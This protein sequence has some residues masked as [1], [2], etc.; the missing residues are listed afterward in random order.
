MIARSDATLFESTSTAPVV[1]I[2]AGPA[3]LTAALELAE[4]GVPVLVVEASTRV[5]GLAQTVEYKGFRFDIGGHRFFTKVPAVRELWRSMLGADF[6]KRPRL[7]R[8]YFDGKFFDYPLKPVN[9]LFN[10]GICREHRDPRQLP[11]GQSPARSHPEVSFEDW[12]TNRFGRRLFRIFFKTYTE[13]V[14]G[15]PCRTISARVGG[16]ADPGPVAADRRHQHAGAVAEP[17][18]GHAGQDADRRVRI[19]AARS[20]DDV[21]SASRRGSRQRGGRSRSNARGRGRPRTTAT[22]FAPS[23]SSATADRCSQPASNVDLDDAAAAI[24]SKSLGRGAPPSVRATRRAGST[25]AT[26]SPW[27]W[28]SIAPSCFPDN[29]IYIHDPAVKVGRIQNFKN[30]SPDMVPDPI[31]DLP[32]ASS[33][34]AP[35]ATSSGRCRTR[36]SSSSRKARAGRDRPGRSPSR[37][38]TAT[39]VRMPKAYPVYDEDYEQALAVD[40][41]ATCR[42]FENLQTDRPQRHAHLQQPGSLD[43]DGRCWRCG[44]CSAS[45][46][47]SGRSISP[48]NIS[49]ELHEGEHAV[50]PLDGR[51]LASTQP[52]LPTLVRAR[53]AFEPRCDAAALFVH[54]AV[55]SRPVD[56]RAMSAGARRTPSRTAN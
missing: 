45:S 13:K 14:W 43:G 7:S 12:V 44:I 9:A 6:L 55:P 49:E 26:S 23:R 52:L 4:L 46:T 51:S 47:T 41:R 31:E 37:S 17:T 50:A 32:R 18:S 21:G 11:L 10:L 54:R 5:G 53:E 34:S 48:T 33:T 30:W 35:R 2:G 28:S 40:P 42:G 25:T 8:I 1:V 15:I 16:A 27:R 36:N 24:W 22:P 19:P 29:W 20:G 38:S 39:V 56:A 3:G